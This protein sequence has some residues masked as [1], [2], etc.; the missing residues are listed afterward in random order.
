MPSGDF[1]RIVVIALSLFFFQSCLQFG[2]FQ[3]E[4]KMIPVGVPK[5]EKY[6]PERLL[7]L[8]SCKCVAGNCF[9]C[10]TQFTMCKTI[11]IMYKALDLQNL[12]FYFYFEIQRTDVPTDVVNVS[13][14]AWSVPS[15]AL[16]MMMM[17]NV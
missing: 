4:G 1:P 3:S 5:S 6:A 11:Y 7:K 16:A 8:I 2:W 15:S 17:I 10:F 9:S 12:T 13:R 14:T